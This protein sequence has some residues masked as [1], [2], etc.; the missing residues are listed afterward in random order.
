MSDYKELKEIKSKIEEG[1]LAYC[2]KIFKVSKPEVSLVNGMRIK[3]ASMNKAG[4]AKFAKQ[5]KDWEEEIKKYRDEFAPLFLLDNFD[6]DDDDCY[7]YE[8]VKEELLAKRLWTISSALAS[9]DKALEKYK[10]AFWGTAPRQL[11]TTI[12]I[13]LSQTNNYMYDYAPLIKLNSVNK[14]EQLKYDFLIAE[15]MLLTGVIGLGIRSEIL[16]RLFPSHFP[17]MTRKSLWGMHYLTAGED[18][19]I[20]D[21]FYENM[22]RTEHNW[23]YDYPRF[24][25]YNLFLSKLLE[26][27]FKEFNISFNNQLRFG[28][29]NLFLNEI[30]TI[31]NDDIRIL[32]EWK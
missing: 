32:T 24:A 15:D 5:I 21:E 2:Y 8:D 16:H 17:I 6:E 13:I 14:I 20:T 28:Y 3:T 4:V 30:S 7:E 1:F 22:Q 27:F 12:K 31:H 19:F 26:S 9:K 10:T 23:N 18:E 11:F 29:A 25:F